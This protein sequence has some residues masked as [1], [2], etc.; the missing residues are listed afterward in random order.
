MYIEVIGIEYFEC[1][2]NELH[3]QLKTLLK[4]QGDFIWQKK[5]QHLKKLFVKLQ[6]EK[7]QRKK[8]FVEQLRNL[9][10][11]DSRQHPE[12]RQIGLALGRS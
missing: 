1:N 11:V 10:L 8:Q 12:L 7:L 6:K 5:E 4:K 9:L 2:S 3:Q